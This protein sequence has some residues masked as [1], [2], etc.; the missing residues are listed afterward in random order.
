MKLRSRPALAWAAAIVM[1]AVS[2]ACGSVAPA[3]SDT[4]AAPGAT[5][6]V[7]TTPSS[8]PASKC[9]PPT[10]AV[11]PPR[12]S[13]VSG[14]I[15]VLAAASLT[16]AF[17]DLAA[18]FEKTEPAAKVA[19]SFG[20][21]SALVARIHEGAPADVLATADTETMGRAVD[22]HDVGE[23]V[24]FTCNT[25]AILTAPGNPLHIENLADLGR[26]GVRFTLCAE[27]V[28]CG[29][30][31][32]KVLADAG[33]DAEPVGSEANVK[34]VVAKVTSGEVDAGIVYVTDARAA[35]DAASSV[36][37]P[38]SV[39]VTTAYPIAVTSDADRPAT[40]R[41]FIDF[42]RSP[43]GQKILDGHGFGRH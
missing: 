39:N 35:A 17:T 22:D 24:D 33:V 6:T 23:P 28:P 26:S 20:A 32:R 43:A 9:T 40:A 25:M 42:V 18:A 37:I 7:K 2:T 31:A 38:A 19:T 41:A 14:S 29:H 16:G 27:P 11:A 30:L 5:A 21:S 12:H 8:T 4:S 3:P 10:D 15:Q 1:I 13:T 36:T 34:A